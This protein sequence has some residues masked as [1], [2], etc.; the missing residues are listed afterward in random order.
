MKTSDSD[1]FRP[2]LGKLEPPGK[3][4]SRLIGQLLARGVNLR[5]ARLS[6]RPVVGSRK[7][8]NFHRGRLRWASVSDRPVVHRGG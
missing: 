1:R 3:V 8:R 7:A 5:R 2:K 4:P 6:P